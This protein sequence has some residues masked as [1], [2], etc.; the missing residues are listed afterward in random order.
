MAPRETPE[1]RGARYRERMLDARTDKARAHAE[2]DALRQDTQGAANAGPVWTQ[3]YGALRTA[4][5]AL[6]RR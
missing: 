2:W 4:R 1:K 3:V 6:K 5:K